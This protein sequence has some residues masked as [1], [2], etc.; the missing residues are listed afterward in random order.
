MPRPNLI[1]AM[2][3]WLDA[4]EI[5]N[6]KVALWICWLIPNRCPFAL[7]IQLGQY[8]QVRIPPLCYL[9]PLYAEFLRLRCKALLCLEPLEPD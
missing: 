7:T 8:H 4:R 9:N 5:Q 6:P 2:G 1:R 3:I